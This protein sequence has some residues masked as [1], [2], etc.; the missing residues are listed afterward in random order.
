MGAKRKQYSASFKREA[1]SLVLEKGRSCRAVERELGL[2]Q[3]VVYR[4][5]RAVKTDPEECFP[6][7]GRLKP[8]DEELRTLKRENAILKRERDILKKA[9]AIFSKEPKRYMNS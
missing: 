3:G 5:V 4:W 7:H 6:G 8:H 2:G 1:V 9:V